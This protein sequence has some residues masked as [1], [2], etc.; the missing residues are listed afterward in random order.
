M[1]KLYEIIKR[2]AEIIEIRKKIIE[3]KMEAI[4]D[5][6]AFYE[7]LEEKLNRRM[8]EDNGTTQS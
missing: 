4:K 2:Q 5:R 7:R 8:E 6:I 3:K 1:K